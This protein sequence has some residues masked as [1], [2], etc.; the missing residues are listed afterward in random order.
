MRQA[1]EGVSATDQVIGMQTLDVRVLLPEHQRGA[2]ADILSL[3]Y[4][5]TTGDLIPLD[6]LIRSDYQ[7][8]LD[9]IR[10][11][12]GIISVEVS[13]TLDT[14]L[15]TSDDMY[16]LL[17]SSVLP[18]FSAQFG[19]LD[20]ELSGDAREQEAFFSDTLVILLVV[21]ALIFGIL[22]W[23]FESWLW[24]FAVLATIPFGLTGAIY[25]HWLIDLPLSSLSVMGLF[26]LAGI[27]IN[28]SIVLV[29][30][31]RDLRQE[32]MPLMDALEEAVARR[33]RPVLLTTMT[34]MAGLAPLLF[35][36]SLDAQF[37]KPIAAGLVF[38][39]LLGTVLILLFVPA[40]LLTIE[41]A[42]EKVQ[43]LRARL[44]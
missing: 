7:R 27:V 24:P 18:E 17:E 5:S 25:G 19:T 15:M 39:L 4:I 22:A 28:D 38:G 23:V 34:T 2:L 20:A 41:R 10:A 11:E 29:S 6:D 43:N 33:L 14:N 26:G 16:R 32:G 13:A 1:L 35:E 8:G 21:L 36:T 12:D 30:V 40:L 3:P 9:Q 31:Y 44:S 42:T 37:L